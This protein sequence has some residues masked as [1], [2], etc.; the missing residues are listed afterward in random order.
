VLRLNAKA[1]LS[2]RFLVLVAFVVSLFLSW[3]GVRSWLISLSFS[4]R[5]IRIIDI[6]V[7]ITVGIVATVL[8]VRLVAGPLAVRAG[9]TESNAIKLLL[10]LSGL[11]LI[12]VAVVFLTGSTGTSFVSALVG[13][14]FFGIVVGLAAQE[15]L[16]NV[17]SGLM[18][19]A[20]RPFH[21]NDR[22]ALISWQ[23]GK[24]PPSLTHGWLEPAYTGVVK[25]IGL[26]YTMILMDS[27]A[28]LKVPNGIVTQ[29]LIINLTH[30]RQGHVATQFEIPLEMDPE[31]L[32]SELKSHLAE[33]AQFKGEEESFE[34]LDISPSACL[35]AVSY[36]VD[37]QRERE[38][39]ALLLKAIRL[40]LIGLGKKEVE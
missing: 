13:V 20:T 18:L 24:F 27:N 2:E 29:S 33:I 35:V 11:V 5:T 34:V 1:S 38:M 4:A 7:V 17:L 16:G 39:K 37:K 26:T 31:H 14:G 10:Q 6:G 36:K 19:I 3:I 15:V 8:V 9:P 30:G 28:L 22:I 32:R 40:A 12:V 23:Y 21:V 25:G